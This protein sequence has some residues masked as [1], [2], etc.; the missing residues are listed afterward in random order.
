MKQISILFLH[1]ITGSFKN[2][3]EESN[4]H[5]VQSYKHHT[6]FTSISLE[7]SSEFHEV[8]IKVSDFQ[9]EMS[10]DMIRVP[11]HDKQ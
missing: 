11:L 1:H 8:T 10:K 6:S 9:Q 2:S 5:Y 7:R 3:H 4:E